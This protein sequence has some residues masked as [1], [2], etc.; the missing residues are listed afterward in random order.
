MISKIQN[1]VDTYGDCD[2]KIVGCFIDGLH[3]D[4]QIRPFNE[5]YEESLITGKVFDIKDSFLID[6]E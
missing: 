2:V 5:Y 1:L 4:F 6:S 3:S